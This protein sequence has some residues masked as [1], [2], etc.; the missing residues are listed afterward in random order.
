MSRTPVAEVDV[1]LIREFSAPLGLV[2]QVW[3]QAEH[4]KEWWGPHCFTNPVCEWDARPGGN[5]LIH[6][7]G[8][9]G[10]VFPMAGTF[11]EV[12]EPNM[13]SFFSAV[14]NEDGGSIIEVLTTVTFA[15]QAGKTVVT[16]NGKGVGFEE[17]AKQMFAG[18]EM[19]W[20]Q[21]LEKFATH[22]ESLA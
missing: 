22:L 1:T 6:M 7:Q 17:I 8:P 16:V 20:S 19:G 13:L 10:S 9:D 15:E 11:R 2:W 21:S 12:A 3:T 18:M 5:I 4:V 14:P